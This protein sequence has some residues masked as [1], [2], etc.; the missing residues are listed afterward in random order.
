MFG[1][2]HTRRLEATQLERDF[3]VGRMR[4]PTVAPTEFF[5]SDTGFAPDFFNAPN[6]RS[7]NGIFDQAAPG[8]ISPFRRSC[9][10]TRTDRCTRAETPSVPATRT[11]CTATTASSTASS[12]GLSADGTIGENQQSNLAST[13]LKRYSLFGRG[14]FE[15]NDNATFFVQ[16]NFNKNDTE[17]ILQFS[18]A[19]NGWAVN[20]PHGTGIFAPSVDAMGNTLPQYLA[21]GSLGLSCA[22]T[23]GCTNSQAFP[24]SPELASVLDSRPSTRTRRGS[25]IACCDFLG[26]RGSVNDSLNYQILAGFSGDLPGRLDLG[27]LSCRMARRRCRSACAASLTCSAIAPWSPRRITGGASSTSATRGPPETALRP[28]P[29]PARRVC[30]SSVTSRCRTTARPRSART[31]RTTPTWTQNIVEAEHAGR[32]VRPAG[33]RAALRRGFRMARKRLPLSDGHPD[34]PGV[35]PG[36]RHRIVPGRQLLRCDRGQGD[37]RRVARSVVA[38]VPGIK[39]LNLELGYRFSDY[40]TVGGVSTYKG[41][42]DWRITDAFRFRGGHQLASRA[43]NIGELFL[44]RT[45]SVAFSSFG[46]FCSR[47]ATAP[48][49]ANPAINPNA[50]ASEGLCRQLM[51]A[52]GAQVYYANPQAPGGFSLALPNTI[53]NPLLDQEEAKSFTA[54]FVFQSG[55]GPPV[56]APAADLDR[57]VLDRDQR[58][59][60]SGLGGHR[61]RPVPE[62]RVQPDLRSDRAGVPAD[63]PRSEQRRTRTRSTCP[64]RTREHTRLRAWTCRS[65]TAWTS[66]TW[67]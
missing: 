21:G 32:T 61:V 11:A 63:R 3:Y 60:R 49:G 38:D 65:T 66:R 67:E 55:L 29:A 42:V 15:I 7:L 59:D 22:A 31:C 14:S 48:S 6:S 18:P 13:P 33:R 20:I 52:T 56:A 24:V 12:A 41:M 62:H 16:G 25:S 4:D 46:D 53:G 2:E 10:S 50:A 39:S 64:T 8:A 5:Y 37:L 57:L 34:Q 23:G 26:P 1:A 9:S 45:Q 17:S 27:S 44:A 54:G 19:S 47:L 35:V 51:G 40:D 28:R 30:R 58:C 43:P 36:R